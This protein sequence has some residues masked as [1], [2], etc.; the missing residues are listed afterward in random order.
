MRD[1]TYDVIV[2]GARVAGATTALLL[3]RQGL[4]VLVL[5]RAAYG[6][7][8][9][10][11]HALMRGGVL[12]LREAGVLGDVIAAGTPA[13][14]RVV[15]HYPDDST[16]V[17]LKATAGVDALYAPR[18]TVLD[19]VL[20][21]A[22]VAAGAD[23]RFGMTVTGLL[24][25]AAGSVS[26][27][28]A[29]DRDGRRLTASSRLT[30]GADGI[31]S[32]VATA[33]RAPL[34]WSAPGPGGAVLY[35]YWSDLP[36]EGYEWYYGDQAGAGLI[37]TNDGRTLVFVGTTP[38]R[39]KAARRNG[40]RAALRAVADAASPEL[41]ERIADAGSPRHLRGF[42]GMSGYL[43][44]PYGRGWALAGDAGGFEDPLSTHGMTDALRDARLLVSA[45]LRI[46]S[47]TAT[48]TEALIEYAAERDALA[49]PLARTVDTIASYRWTFPKL[50]R[51]LLEA[52]AAMSAQVEAV[53]RH[54]GPAARLPVR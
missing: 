7:D 8:T 11:T 17:T 49:L 25:D 21:D 46:R 12:Q 5:D 4:R 15:F 13:V 6:S 35:G 51:L 10:S 14:R 22:A 30:I 33:A 32:A 45:V 36:T 42:A 34:T 24:R 48:E 1:S 53:L 18:R 9:G 38:Q 37:P 27:V 2:V 50:R 16:T 41:W 47:G 23:V 39:M 29:V 44:R 3:A 31:G 52:N 40:T 19:R 43:R 28:A 20:V 54:S 26:G